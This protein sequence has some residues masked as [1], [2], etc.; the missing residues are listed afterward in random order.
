MKIIKYT[1]SILF[2]S[3]VIISCSDGI[4]TSNTES[5]FNPKMFITDTNL[6]NEKYL[7]SLSIFALELPD[8]ILN[9]WEDGVD[10]SFYLMLSPN[11]TYTKLVFSSKHEILKDTIQIFHKNELFFLS[12]ECGFILNFKIDSIINTWN[13]IDS[14]YLVEDEITNDV[15]GLLKIYM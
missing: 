7:D 1:I 2:L 14:I 3:S 4:C 6:I 9:Y 12:P 8:S 13:L 5:F 11:E 10:S 15:N